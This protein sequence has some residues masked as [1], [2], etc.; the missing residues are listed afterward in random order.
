VIRRLSPSRW[1]LSPWAILWL[2]LVWV[3]LWGE[4]TALTVAGGV[5]VAVIV[6]GL[7]P[8]PHVHMR[9]RPRLWPLV[10]LIVRYSYDLVTASVQVAWLSVRPGELAGGVVMDMEL[11]GDDE[12]L[13]VLTAEM[14]TLVPGSV[15]IELDPANRVLTIHA[16]DVHTRQEAEVM[17]RR[18]RAQEARI[19]RALHPDPESLLNPRHRREAQRRA[20]EHGPVSEAAAEARRRTGRT[21]DEVR[22]DEDTQGPDEEVPR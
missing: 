11:M 6:L 17:R 16:L 2:T 21:I 7:F 4:V 9:L 1:R 18:I 8:V 5:L 12:L 20:A 22:P 15:V 13:Q 19:L 3:M 10:V 14:V